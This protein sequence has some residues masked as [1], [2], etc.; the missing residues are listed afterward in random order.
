[1][2]LL[3]SMLGTTLLAPFLAF[4]QGYPSKPMHT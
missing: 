2:R 3:R 1:M 4:A